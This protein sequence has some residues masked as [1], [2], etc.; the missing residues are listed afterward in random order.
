[1][2]GNKKMYNINYFKIIAHIEGWIFFLMDKTLKYFID[3][4]ICTLNCKGDNL[5]KIG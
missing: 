5:P 1:M 3:H 4:H 2:K